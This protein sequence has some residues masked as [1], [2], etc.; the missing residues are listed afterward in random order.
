[1][2][3][4]EKATQNLEKALSKHIHISCSSPLLPALDEDDD[5]DDDDDAVDDPVGGPRRMRAPIRS[6]ELQGVGMR[7]LVG[8]TPAT[9]TS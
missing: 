6:G 4:R 9:C 5:D 8:S 1:M 7:L 2:F 3:L